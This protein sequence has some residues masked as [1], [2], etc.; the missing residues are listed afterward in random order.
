MIYTFLKDGSAPVYTDFVAIRESFERNYILALSLIGPEITVKSYRAMFINSGSYIAQNFILSKP[1]NMEFHNV[2]AHWSGYKA[3][4]IKRVGQGYQVFI[5]NDSRAIYGRTREELH[6]CLYNLLYKHNIPTPTPLDPEFHECMEKILQVAEENQCINACRILPEENSNKMFIYEV[7]TL[8]SNNFF[9]QK[10]IQIVTEYLE[11]ESSPEGILEGVEGIADYIEKYAGEISRKIEQRI[12]YLH[13]PRN[14]NEGFFNGLNRRL[15][16]HQKDIAVAAAKKLAKDNKVIISGQMGVGKTTIGVAACHY[17]SFLKGQK[18]YRTIITCP[19]HLQEKWAREIKEVLPEA[20]VFCFIEE[21]KQKPW[22]LFSRKIR[23][24]VSTPEKPEYWIVSNESLRSGYLWRPAYATKKKKL[25][26]IKEEKRIWQDVC[27]CPDCGEYLMKEVETSDYRKVLVHMIPEDFK[28]RTSQ[29]HHCPKCKAA[30]WQADEKKKGYRK[31]AIIELIKKKLAKNFF[32][33]YIADEAHKYKGA[34]AQGMAFGGLIEASKNTIAMTGTLADGYANGLYYLLWRMKPEKFKAK[35]Y[36]YNEESR[37][38]FQMEYGFWEKIS[39]TKEKEYGKSSRSYRT[40]TYTKILPGYTINTFPEWLMEETLF[41]KLSD[42][43]SELPPKKEYVNV[44]PMDEDLAENYRQI[45]N[46]FKTI[47]NSTKDFSYA[48]LMLHTCMSYPDLGIQERVVKIEGYKDIQI[49]YLDRS[50]LYN[51]EIE[52]QKIVRNELAQGRKCIIFTTYTNNHDCL[53]RLEWVL[54]GVEGAKVQVLRADTVNSAKRESYISSKLLEGKNVLVCH[55]GLV[56][57]GL[58]LLEFPTIIWMQTGF[59][60]SVVRQASARS[61]RIGQT[62]EVKIIFLCYAGTMQ[63]KCF[64]LVGQKINAAGILEG[65]L[66]NEGLRRFGSAGDM[67][68]VLS[69]LKDNITTVNANDIF[70][71]YKTE[72]A[73]I[74]EFKKPE[75]KI[76]T[77]KEKLAEQGIDISKLPA[78]ERKKIE[79]QQNQLVLLF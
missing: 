22:Q 21:K 39:K 60:P 36:Q 32:D 50:K 72:T 54:N 8:P 57:T 61:W 35:G 5:I 69:L 3:L 34:T 1:E 53:P 59:V 76:Q 10:I 38:R 58:D 64:A 74:L 12:T 24:A 14:Y 31:I 40:Q 79:Q 23:E 13:T 6:I 29:N 25:Y 71:T 55:P 42:V 65:N 46:D 75:P 51:K 33:Y 49:P 17:K 26:S 2:V 4:P 43:T 18:G 52:L 70:E 37:N 62:K 16:P 56:E 48:S 28:S 63:E 78:R 19:S 67:I 9:Q 44:V 77:L 27:I 15:Y 30:L 47:I 7:S 11:E 66:D 41:L 45:E 73:Q 20:E 68:D